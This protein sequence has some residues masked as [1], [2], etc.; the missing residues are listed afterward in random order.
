MN[1]KQ[2]PITGNLKLILDQ[3]EL[4]KGTFII[5]GMDKVE[6]LV[7]IGDDEMDWY[8]VTYNGRKFTWHS[9]VGGFVQLKNKIDEKDYN[10]FIRLA[11]LNHY[12]QPGLWG[13]KGDIQVIDYNIIHKQDMSKL[14]DNHKFLTEICWDL[15]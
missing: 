2:Q 4:S 11:K 5:T 14:P 1:I 8:W 13:N 10:E 9:C 3:F 7:A 6:R 12:D 15:N